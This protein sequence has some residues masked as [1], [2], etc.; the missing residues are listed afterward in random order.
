[1]TEQ[2]DS[3][4]PKPRTR[5]RSVVSFVVAA[6]IFAAITFALVALLTSIVHRKQ[7]A[8]NPF[9]RLVEVEENTTDPAV[10]GT[11]WPK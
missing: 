1:M 5:R 10:W 3:T 9:V 6:V 7:E 8:K 2:N 4:D 11:N